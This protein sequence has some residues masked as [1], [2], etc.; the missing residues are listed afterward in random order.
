MEPLRRNYNRIFS[1]K[2]AKRIINVLLFILFFDFLFF[3]LPVLA[4]NLENAKDLAEI[5]QGIVENYS[6]FKYIVYDRPENHLPVNEDLKV[7]LAGYY[8]IT[9]YNSEV[10]QTDNSPCITA[11][12]FNVCQHG[13]EDTV[14][15]NFLNF[16]DKVRIPELF[17]DRV[18]VVRDRMNKR[19]QNRVDIWMVEK[20]DAKQFGVKLAKVEVLE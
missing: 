17:G 4:A 11:N 19:H 12:G 6:D 5:S 13:V 3:P 18:F 10:G 14:A 15:A 16:G 9:A 1:L 20:Q 8:T 7:K 2:L